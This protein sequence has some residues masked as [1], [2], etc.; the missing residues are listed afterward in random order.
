MN[1]TCGTLEE[2]QSLWAIPLNLS[3]LEVSSHWK[4]FIQKYQF[5]LKVPFLK[6]LRGKIKITDNLIPPVDNL[7]L[8]VKKLQLLVPTLLTHD[9]AEFKTDKKP[10]HS[11]V[12]CHRKQQVCL[13][14]L[15]T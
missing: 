8:S 12:I 1:E 11:I 15:Q 4:A 13:L 10:K 6:K 7:Q 5:R 3:L 9:A 2:G 14:A